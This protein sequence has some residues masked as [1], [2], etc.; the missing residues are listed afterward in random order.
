VQ[1]LPLAPGSEEVFTNWQPQKLKC[2]IDLEKK[3]KCHS[4]VNKSLKINDPVFEVV[5]S[6]FTKRIFHFGFGQNADEDRIQKRSLSPRGR[7]TF[8][9][10]TFPG[11]EVIAR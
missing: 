4:K 7:R 10:N 5:Q 1:L 6:V 8:V 3:K 11:F 2:L 9:R